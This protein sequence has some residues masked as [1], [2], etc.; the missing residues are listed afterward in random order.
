MEYFTDAVIQKFQMVRNRLC[1]FCGVILHI[2][3]L[4]MRETFSFESG[5]HHTMSAKSGNGNKHFNY[6]LVSEGKW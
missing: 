2:K 4:K 1:F 5:H 6:K 3:G